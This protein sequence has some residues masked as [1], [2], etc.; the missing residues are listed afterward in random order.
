MNKFQARTSYV[1]EK[2]VASTNRRKPKAWAITGAQST[3]F[4]ERRAH[5]PTPAETSLPPPSPR[6]V[7][8]SSAPVAPSK[9]ASAAALPQA[10]ENANLPSQTGPVVPSRSIA[11]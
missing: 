4:P 10:S 8:H 6:R 2:A 11:L 1:A 3:S 7:P 5:V 9:S